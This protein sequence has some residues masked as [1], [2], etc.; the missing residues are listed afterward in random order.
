[1]AFVTWLRRRV[2]WLRAADL[3]L[4]AELAAICL[5]LLAFAYLG[6]TFGIGVGD[7]DRAILLALRNA[8]DDPIGSRNVENTIIHLSAL[9][10]VAV[11]TLIVLI[12]VAFL[13]LARRWRY[14]VLVAI[15]AAGAQLWMK[16]LK[17]AYDRPRPSMVSHL[18]PPGGL[19]FPSGHALVSA[20]LYLTLGVLLARTLKERRLRIF[21]VATAAFLALVIGATRVYMGV[22]YP[23][24]VL[25]GWCVGL[26][27]ALM[28]GIVARA[29]ARRHVVEARP[30]G[31]TDGSEP[32]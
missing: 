26:V 16:L 1:M 28:C 3:R 32:S 21:V 15:A 29:L 8:P 25:G 10:S 2:E 6:S 9:G 23:T 30:P 24:D 22:H 4:T 7:F 18:D 12:V 5:L 17:F 13:L 14:A 20:T 11:T 31:A 19:S 27:W